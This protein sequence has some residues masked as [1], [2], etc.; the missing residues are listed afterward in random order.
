MFPRNNNCTVAVT[1]RQTPRVLITR[2]TRTVSS[3]PAAPPAYCT[4]STTNPCYAPVPP[5]SHQPDTSCVAT[6]PT[7][8]SSD[9]IP[10]YPP[11]AYTPAAPTNAPIPVPQP[12]S[13]Q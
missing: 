2:V 9:N 11:P 6:N 13:T 3:G 12:D 7:N 4:S 5:N 10:S 1:Q 8:Y